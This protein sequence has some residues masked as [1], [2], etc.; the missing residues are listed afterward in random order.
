MKIKSNRSAAKRFRATG[1]GKVKR[2]KAYARHLLSSKNRKR[3]RQLGKSAVVDS[4]NMAGI[5]RML[6]YL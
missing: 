6:P 1:T 2:N 3:K 4:A 5:R